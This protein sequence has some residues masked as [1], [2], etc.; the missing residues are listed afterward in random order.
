MGVLRVTAP[1]SLEAASASETSVKFYHTTGHNNPQTA[2]TVQYICDVNA[3]QSRTL[4]TQ[5]DLPTKG[6]TLQGSALR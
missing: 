6:K 5:D 3:V 2:R 4:L 1:C